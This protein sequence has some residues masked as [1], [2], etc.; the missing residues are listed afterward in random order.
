MAAI[1]A[2]VVM[3]ANT[4]PHDPREPA[5]RTCRRC[6]DRFM[7]PAFC[8]THVGRC[9]TCCGKAGQ[10]CP[11]HAMWATQPREARPAPTDTE[12]AQVEADIDALYGAEGDR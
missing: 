4:Y 12:R 1:P 3:S 8:L 5:L 2:V 11:L 7:P 9:L 10:L 6:E